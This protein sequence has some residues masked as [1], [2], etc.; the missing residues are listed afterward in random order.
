MAAVFI[1][2]LSALL[3]GAIFAGAYALVA[4]ERRATLFQDIHDTSAHA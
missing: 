3:F 4:W 1:L 2:G